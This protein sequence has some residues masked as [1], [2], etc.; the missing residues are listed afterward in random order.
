MSK[1][2]LVTGA[3]SGIGL[4]VALG[5][6]KKGYSVYGAARRVEL[7][8]P[9]LKNGG[10]VLAL[11]LCDENSIEK[12][13]G[14]ILEREGHVDLLVNNAGFGLGGSIEEIPVEE[15]RRQFDVNVFG[16]SK[17]IQLVL[18]SMRAQKS[19][20]IINVSSMAGRFTT[21][22]SGWYHASKYCVESLSDALRLEVK[23]FGIKVVLI[24]PGMI[25]TDW[26]VIH[27]RNIRRYSG[28]G[29][30]RENAGRVASYYEKRYVQNRKL[31]PAHK[32]SRLIVCVAGK[33]RVRARYRIGTGS[34]L[35]ILIKKF[36]PDCVFDFLAVKFLNQTGV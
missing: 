24:E 28:E 18:P 20:C 30:Y 8:E 32:V 3:S 7:M 17:I 16:L 12:C 19:G 31:T 33:K 26:G 1:V 34:F 11:D 5:L 4:D 15:V 13:V 21:P 14:A 22:Y 6:L 35:F 25:Q 27:G 10:H 23:P 2:A 9:L 36:V 29:D